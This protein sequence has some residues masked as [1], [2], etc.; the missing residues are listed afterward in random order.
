VEVHFRLEAA[1]D[2]GAEAHA[3]VLLVHD[4]DLVA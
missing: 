3:T 2:G 4:K 1:L